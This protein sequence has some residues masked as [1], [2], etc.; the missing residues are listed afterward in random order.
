VNETTGGLSSLQFPST[1][2]LL[3]PQ[4]DDTLALPMPKSRK[5]AKLFPV[6]HHRQSS[7]KTGEKRSFDVFAMIW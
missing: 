6:N 1:D 4:L 3:Q 7:Q 5:N 2:C